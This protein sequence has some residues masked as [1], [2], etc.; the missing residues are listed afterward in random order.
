LEMKIFEL[1]VNL[2]NNFNVMCQS[3]LQY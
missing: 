1:F 3:S 2:N